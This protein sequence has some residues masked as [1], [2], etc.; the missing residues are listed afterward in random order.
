MDDILIIIL[1]MIIEMILMIICMII[2]MIMSFTC[3]HPWAR[4][5]RELS[6]RDEHDET[7]STWDFYS[8]LFLFFHYSIHDFDFL[9]DHLKLAAMPGKELAS[10]VWELFAVSKVQSLNIV[11]MLSK[12]WQ[13]RVTHCLILSGTLVVVKIF[14]GIFLPD[15][16]LSW[17]FLRSRRIFELNFL[18][19]SLP[20]QP[21]MKQGWFPAC[22]QEP[23]FFLQSKHESFFRKYCG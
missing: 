3:G 6:D 18:Q 23:Y 20:R 21:A 8:K 2:T 4:A 10:P 5:R 16:R 15:I 1:V 12:C 13:G 17:G 22:D 9:W 14:W 19:L 7:S 11:A